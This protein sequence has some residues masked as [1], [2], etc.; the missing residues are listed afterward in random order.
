MYR[1]LFS[2]LVIAGLV[3]GSLCALC[4]ADTP[5][6]FL[7]ARQANSVHGVCQHAHDGDFA[8]LRGH[9]IQIK[10]DTVFTFTDDDEHKIEVRFDEG[11]VPRDFELGY[12]YYLWGQMHKETFSRSYL[13]AVFLSP[14]KGK[15]RN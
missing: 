6:P 14:K 7:N 3:T 13:Q 2:A 9:F 4:Q 15:A 12:E 5:E 11:S 1:I 8:L 10:D